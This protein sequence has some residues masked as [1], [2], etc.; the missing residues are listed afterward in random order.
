MKRC[1]ASTSTDGHGGSRPLNP[2]D[3]PKVTREEVEDRA[4]RQLM[5]LRR[6]GRMWQWWDA[7]EWRNGY[8]TNYL[9]LQWLSRNE[10]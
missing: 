2:A 9:M 8:Q 4:R 10:R 1:N 3:A 6:V 7:F 5:R